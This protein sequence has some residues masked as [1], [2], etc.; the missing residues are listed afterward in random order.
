MN[1]NIEQGAFGQ[2]T[3]N[4]QCFLM[5]LG[6]IDWTKIHNIKPSVL[7]NVNSY[8]E[9]QNFF[10]IPI[11]VDRYLSLGTKKII[12]DSISELILLADIL[13]DKKKEYI[14]TNA[15]RELNKYSIL[16]NEK[17]II[18]NDLKI[19]PFMESDNSYLLLIESKDETLL[20]TCYYSDISN[21]ILNLTEKIKDK[22]NNKKIDYLVT[23]T[24]HLSDNVSEIMKKQKKIFL[25]TYDINTQKYY[26]EKAIEN[27]I[28]V[29][30][31]YTILKQIKNN[32]EEII[33]K[34]PEC[35][36]NKNIY[37]NQRKSMEDNFLIFIEESKLYKDYLMNFNGVKAS[38]ISTNPKSDI[39][40]LSK[41]MGFNILNIEK[42]KCS[43]ESMDIIINILEP[44]KIIKIN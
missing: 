22:L 41:E 9:I 19:T 28:N 24:G 42:S 31:P 35:E 40:N 2:I 30:A 38:L 36:Q 21:N 32:V 27:N 11:N 8:K 1:I 3:T 23:D 10:N 18:I 39:V 15:L 6:K 5:N 7:L 14:Y 34:E 13:K 16:E 43:K 25:L 37:F 33:F 26:K 12:K 29:Y 4:N 20:W 17:S 44:N